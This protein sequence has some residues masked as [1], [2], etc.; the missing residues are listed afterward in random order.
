MC[1]HDQRLGLGEQP[2]LYSAQYLYFTARTLW[3]GGWLV[4]FKF[5]LVIIELKQFEFVELQQL[6]IIIFR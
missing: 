6:F 2:K 4:F 3:R 1:N 5:R